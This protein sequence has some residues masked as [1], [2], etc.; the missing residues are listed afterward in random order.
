LTSL[1]QRVAANEPNA[2][3]ECLER[4]GALVWTIARRF[5]R[6][7]ADAEDAAQEAFVEIWSKAAR[8]DPARASEPAFLALIVRR[9]LIDRARRRGARVH[10]EELDPEHPLEAP[11]LSIESV[12][13]ADEARQAT[14]A[15]ATLR[16]EHRRALELSIY[17]GLSHEEISRA[18]AAP[19]GT[20]KT[21]IRSGLA[22]V[23]EH[24]GVTPPV[25]LAPTREARR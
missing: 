23:R 2:V 20:V 14:A 1:L 22:R 17:H 15:L 24:L 13:I 25:P 10:A 19:L 9:K 7:A 18:I 6:D 16:P 11:P 5:S 21:Y 8:F 4:Y 12:E 3:R